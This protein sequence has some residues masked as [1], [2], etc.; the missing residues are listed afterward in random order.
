MKASFLF[1]FLFF[2]SCD[3]TKSFHQQISSAQE[4]IYEGEYKKAAKLYKKIAEQ[5]P[6]QPLRLKSFYQFGSTLRA[7]P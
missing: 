4:A 1:F 5:T 3:S 6:R 7:L 2:I